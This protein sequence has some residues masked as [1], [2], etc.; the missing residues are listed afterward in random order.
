MDKNRYFYKNGM[1]V[2]ETGTS[3]KQYLRARGVTFGQRNS[4]STAW[5]LPHCDS[6]TTVLGFSPA[7]SR[8]RYSAYGFREA[9]ANMPALGFTGQRLEKVT[10]CYPLGNGHRFYSPLLMRFIQADALSPFSAGGTN[11]YA[12]CQ[13]DPINRHDPSGR[14]FEWLR[15]R[16]SR[17]NRRL[18]PQTP[19][20]S[21]RSS[22]SQQDTTIDIGTPTPPPSRRNSLTPEPTPQIDRLGQAA[23]DYTYHVIDNAVD[24]LM[25]VPSRIARQ[26]DRLPRPVRSAITFIAYGP[27]F[28]Q[29]QEDVQVG[30]FYGGRFLPAPTAATDVSGDIRTGSFVPVSPVAFHTRNPITEQPRASRN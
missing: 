8:C 11:A 26:W 6:A 27:R 20:P 1:L 5:H 12:Y 18:S 29:R 7:P 10:G 4:G 28:N 19:P 23:L 21:R 14:F 17:L 2:T 3:S 9:N 16:V 24:D 13:N 30:I 15:Q 22:L 25:R